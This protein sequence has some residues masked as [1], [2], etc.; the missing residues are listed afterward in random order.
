MPSSGTLFR[1]LNNV[2]DLSRG[3]PTRRQGYG[4]SH[5]DARVA[6]GHRCRHRTRTSK[7]GTR[8]MGLPLQ[9]AATLHRIWQANLWIHRTKS[10]RL[11]RR[12]GQIRH[13]SFPRNELPNV[14]LASAQEKAL[15][16][17]IMPFKALS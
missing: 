14:R 3:C 5:G 4:A 7:Q 13:R 16:Y 11:Q 10:M 17:L 9:R 8:R 2:A 6:Q 12:A 1:I 15:I